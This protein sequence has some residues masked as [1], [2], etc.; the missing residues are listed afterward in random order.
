MNIEA[1]R[2]ADG[3]S[4][5]GLFLET[6]ENN[7]ICLFI[8]GC[9]GNFVDNDFMRIIGM[10]LLKNQYNV[11]CANTRGSFM[12][13]SSFHPQNLERPKQIGVAYECF[14]DCV[15]DI[16]AWIE[17]LINKGYKSIDVICHSS[18]ANKFIYYMNCNF[19][20]KDF[21]NNII[22]LSPPDFANRIRCYSDYD[23][24]IKEA[25][26]NVKKGN[27][28]KLI[29]IHFFYKTSIE[30]L[31]MMNSKNFD[32]LPLVNGCKQDFYQYS[33][34]TNPMFIIYGEEENYIKNFVYKFIQF[35]NPITNVECCEINGADHIYFGKEEEIGIEII[36]YLNRNN[37][38]LTTLPLYLKKK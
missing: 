37:L 31:K 12:M 22:F 3:I 13:N 15:Y 23:E 35:A 11:L 8:P 38:H 20:N 7:R 24:L 25:E 5:K 32:K 27:S 26:E 9:C 21:I 34:I 29:K 4:L 14:E 18:G 19:K 16:D 33:N 10:T 2:T 6:K 36:S 17:C 1:I 28:N 30:F